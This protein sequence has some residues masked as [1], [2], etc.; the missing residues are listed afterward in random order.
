LTSFVQIPYFNNFVLDPHH[1]QPFTHA[2]QPTGGAG[3][4]PPPQAYGLQAPAYPPPDYGRGGAH[5]GGFV[6]YPPFWGE[7]YSYPSGHPTG[8]LPP[9]R[10][11]GNARRLSD[12][13]SG[14]APGYDASEMLAAPASAGLPAKPPAML[15][16]G[17]GGRRGGRTGSMSGA[18]PPPPPDAKEDPRA[19]A[20][21]KV[22]YHDMDL[23]AEGDVELTY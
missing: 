2:P 1:I 6:G 5:H 12:R 16:P 4:A 20:G 23:V 10:E 15:E 17:P 22:S 8:Y 19:T 9:R 13:I 21:K 11:E 18:L 7:P 3:Q 14:Y